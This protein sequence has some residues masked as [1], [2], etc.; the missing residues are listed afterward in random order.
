MTDKSVIT[1]NNHVFLLAYDQG[2]E[3]GPTDFNEKNVD[4][5][6]ILNIARD[7]GVYTGIIFHEGIA[8]NYYD[9][10]KETTPLIIKLNGKTS[11]HA[12]EEPYSPQLCT[13]KEAIRLG[14]KA[15]GY[16]IYIGSEHEATM[17][18]EFSQIEDEAHEA[19][20]VVILWTYPRGKNVAGRENSREV[21]AYASRLALEL[22]A[23]FVKLPYPGDK[24]SFQWIV[25]SAGK[26]G[27]LVQGGTK[28]SEEEFLTEIA[29]C[30]SVGAAG[31]AVGRNIWQSDNPVELSKKA[32]AI[33]YG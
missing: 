7:S 32:A 31:V 2:F 15:V 10:I 3:H 9:P 30:M 4:P 28:K 23:D 8:E 17:M 6:Y 19:G 27:V 14:A 12:N 1:K 20:L 16:T 33:I 25:E 26:T 18:K 22:S 24:E 5:E 29:D 11:F 21:L 13:V